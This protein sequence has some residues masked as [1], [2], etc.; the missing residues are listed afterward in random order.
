MEIFKNLPTSTVP[1]KH[2]FLTMVSQKIS[3]EQN[4][5]CFLVKQKI[6]MIKN[7]L[8]DMSNRDRLKPA[9]IYNVT[10]FNI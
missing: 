8:T 9:T 5:K 3:L 1:S 6:P 4:A 2:I 7:I 10:S